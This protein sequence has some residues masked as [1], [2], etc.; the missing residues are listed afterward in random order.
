MKRHIWATYFHLGSSDRKLKHQ[1]CL[2]GS[3]A[4]CKLQKHLEKYETSQHH[5]GCFAREDDEGRLRISEKDLEVFHL[6]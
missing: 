4:W 2:K 1:I 5:N 3:D 6:T